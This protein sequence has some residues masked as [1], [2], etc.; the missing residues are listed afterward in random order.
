MARRRKKTKKPP[1][2]IQPKVD[3]SLPAL[4]PSAATQFTPDIDTPSEQF[5]EPPTTDVSPRPAQPR[6]ND[7]SPANFR[8]EASPA[9]QNDARKGTT[10]LLHARLCILLMSAPQ[11]MSPYPLVPIKK[12]ITRKLPI[13][14][15]TTASCFPLL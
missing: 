4:P 2:T 13:L 11:I 5:S 10:T 7:S 6:R 3:K 9:S 15:T 1:S 8:R 12:L 14:V